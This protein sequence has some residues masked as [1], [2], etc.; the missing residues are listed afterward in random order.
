MFV[1]VFIVSGC[2]CNDVSLHMLTSTCVLSFTIE[3]HVSTSSSCSPKC[4]MCFSVK[5]MPGG[6]TEGKALADE[7]AGRGRSQNSQQ[8]R[9]KKK[10]KM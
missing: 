10:M 7:V 9:E 1:P 4:Q 8:R 5:L 3:V 2:V 6:H